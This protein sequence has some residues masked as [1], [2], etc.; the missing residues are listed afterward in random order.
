MEIETSQPFVIKCSVKELETE[1]LGNK[2]TPSKR[3]ESGTNMPK[4]GRMEPEHSLEEDKHGIRIQARKRA[5]KK[6]VYPNLLL[7]KADHSQKR[8]S[9]ITGI[10][11]RHLL[12]AGVGG[13][14]SILQRHKDRGSA[15]KERV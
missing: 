2:R 1:G 14:R 7:R 10:L 4:K 8:K 3:E 11:M 15:C 5:H 12:Q 6:R 9:C 13:P